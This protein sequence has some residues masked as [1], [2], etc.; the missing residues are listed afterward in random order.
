MKSEAS[1]ESP[2]TYRGVQSATPQPTSETTEVTW[3][4]DRN[5]FV[6][7]TECDVPVKHSKL[8]LKVSLD[9]L[10]CISRYI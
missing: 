6:W 3:Y 8:T 7:P 4:L 2:V 10:G 5:V 9:E 1:P